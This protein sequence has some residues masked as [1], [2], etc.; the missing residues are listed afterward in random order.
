MTMRHFGHSNRFVTYLLT[1]RLTRSTDK[2]TRLLT[3]PLLS[4]LCLS[5]VPPGN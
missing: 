2:A 1:Y 5:V 4:V 3:A